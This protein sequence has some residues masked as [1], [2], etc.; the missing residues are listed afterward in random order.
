MKQAQRQYD[1]KM[2]DWRLKTLTIKIYSINKIILKN[3]CFKQTFEQNVLINFFLFM[4]RRMPHQ[5]D[6]YQVRKSIFLLNLN[7]F[8]IQNL[9]TITTHLIDEVEKKTCERCLNDKRLFCECVRVSR[10]D[11]YFY[12]NDKCINCAIRSISCSL[13]RPKKFKKIEK[14]VICKNGRI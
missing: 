3:F 10:Q 9:K 14:T 1:L 11:N 13:V 12:L 8:K 6:F 5:R 4:F 2:K 7:V